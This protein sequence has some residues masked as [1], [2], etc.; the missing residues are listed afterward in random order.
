MIRIS[1]TYQLSAPTVSDNDII[2]FIMACQR[3][4]ITYRSR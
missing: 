1:P 4:Y 2:P 3:F